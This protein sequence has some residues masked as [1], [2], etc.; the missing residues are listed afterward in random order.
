MF[1]LKYLLPF[2]LDRAHVTRQ[3]TASLVVMKSDQFFSSVLPLEA[4]GEVKTLAFTGTVLVIGCLSSSLGE[5]VRQKEEY[6]LAFLKREV[7]AVHVSRVRIQ[8][9]HT[10]FPTETS[11]MIQ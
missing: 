6:L 1:S 9:L 10:F 7:P 11:S 8:I 3:V 4:Q 2:A 5:W